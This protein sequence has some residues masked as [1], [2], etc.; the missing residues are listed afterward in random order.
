MNINITLYILLR[1]HNILLNLIICSKVNHIFNTFYIL[2]TINY[3][4]CQTKVNL[5]KLNL[6]LRTQTWTFLVFFRIINKNW[7]SLQSFSLAILSN[8]SSHTKFS[9][10][11][12]CHWNIS[13]LD[14][15]SHYTFLNFLNS[16]LFY[17]HH[18][19]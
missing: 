5:L 19:S 14:L 9:I 16:I 11:W 3:Y 18:V 17:F 8:I 6:G 4:F 12:S 2:F 7:T 13:R 15:W 10:I 1:F